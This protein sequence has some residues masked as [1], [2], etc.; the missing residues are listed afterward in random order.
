MQDSFFDDLLTSVNQMAAIEK[1]DVQPAAE[2]I[3]HHAIPDVKKL[4]TSM[5]MKQAEFA[6]AVGASVGLVQS[7]ELHRRIP[8]GIALKVLNVLEKEPRFIEVLKAV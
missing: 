7:W 2:Q 5:G 1:G 8:T 3:H 6:K 4:R